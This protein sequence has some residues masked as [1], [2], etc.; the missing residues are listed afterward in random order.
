LV[1]VVVYNSNDKIPSNTY[2]EFWLRSGG[3]NCFKIYIHWSM[4]KKKLYKN[5]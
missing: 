5:I 1:M 2:W 4:L 3:L